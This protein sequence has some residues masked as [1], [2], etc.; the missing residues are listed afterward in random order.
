MV[1]WHHQLNG[2]RFE[3]TPGDSEEQGSLA[4]GSTWGHM[5][6]DTTE[7]EQQQQLSNCLVIFLSKN[8][9]FSRDYFSCS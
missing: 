9:E 7:C 8:S 4:W 6:L 3:Q 5:E 1:E 2:Y